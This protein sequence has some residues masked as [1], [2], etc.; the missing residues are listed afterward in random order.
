M[1][2]VLAVTYALVPGFAQGTVVD[3]I[4]CV[5]SDAAV[6]PVN[7]PLS[8]NV[9]PGTPS[10]TFANVPAGTYNFS[11]AG[12]DASNNVLGTPVTGSI[13]IAVPTTISL[14]LPSAVSASQS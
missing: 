10:V 13:T 7:P 2:A 12:Q 5:L 6:P 11:V 1:N 14:S 9:A 3:H 8:Q 4:A